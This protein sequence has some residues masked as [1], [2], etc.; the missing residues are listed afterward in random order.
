MCTS[1]STLQYPAVHYRSTRSTHFLQYPQYPQYPAVPTGTATTARAVPTVPT[2]PCSTCGYCGYCTVPI[3][4]TVPYSTQRQY[5]QYR[6]CRSTHGYCAVPAGV[7]TISTFLRALS[8][9]YIHGIP[10]LTPTLVRKF[11]PPLPCHLL[12]SP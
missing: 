7:T 1:C 10:K 2:V 9:G 8:C 11:P 6:A 3:V 5:P 12:W 4:P